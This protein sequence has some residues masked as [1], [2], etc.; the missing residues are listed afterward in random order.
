MKREWRALDVVVRP[1]RERREDAESREGCAVACAR[2]KEQILRLSFEVIEVGACGQLRGR[3]VTSMLNTSGPQAG[4][5]GNGRAV[6][7]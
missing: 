5:H 4:Q 1:A 2:G 6:I 7:D 3:H